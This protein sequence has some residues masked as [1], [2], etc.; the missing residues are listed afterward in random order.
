ME[1]CGDIV[2]AIWCVN[3][4]R[5]ATGQKPLCVILLNMLKVEMVAL[6]AAHKQV[7][8]GAASPM[9][10]LPEPAKMTLLFAD[11]HISH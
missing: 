2:A 6:H 10:F 3:R 5:P 8:C 7:K 9:G 11:P 4:A 1:E